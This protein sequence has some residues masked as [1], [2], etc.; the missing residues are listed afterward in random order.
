[1]AILD[2]KPAGPFTSTGEPPGSTQC[3]GV[4]MAGTA[5]SRMGDVRAMVRLVRQAPVEGEDAIG[6]RRQLLA[7]LCRLLGGHYDKLMR[8]DG[9]PLARRQAQ[10]LSYLL[11]GDSEKQIASRLRLSPNTVHVYVR[12]LYRQFG[13]C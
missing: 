13:V 10:T 7:D 2:A 8:P 5:Q 3:E 9:S 12:E 4:A 11:R 6:H 1:M